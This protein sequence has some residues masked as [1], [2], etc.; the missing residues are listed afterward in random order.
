MGFRVCGTYDTRRKCGDD[1]AGREGGGEE[2]TAMQM[3]VRACGE[4]G[5][6]GVGGCMLK[7]VILEDLGFGV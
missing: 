5:G 7:M 2:V 1:V 3:N 4:G 6:G